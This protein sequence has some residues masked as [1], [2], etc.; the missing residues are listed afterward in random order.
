MNSKARG[1]RGFIIPLFTTAYRPLLQHG[2]DPSPE[3][4]FVV[5]EAV[6]AVTPDKHG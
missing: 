3:E 1:F 6:I 4:F 5:R 2:A